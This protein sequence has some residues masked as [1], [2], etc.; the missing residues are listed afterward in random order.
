[1]TTTTT[2]LPA[3]RFGMDKLEVVTVGALVGFLAASQLSVAPAYIMLA[4][5][6]ACWAAVVWVHHE[7]IQVPVM[8][9]WRAAYGVATLFSALNSAVPKISLEDCKQLV[10]FLIVPV[11]YRFASGPRALTF[12]TVIIT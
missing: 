1:M 9:W 8:F 7:R 12:A 2:A 3:P 5:T 6:F 10:M 4:I 11:V